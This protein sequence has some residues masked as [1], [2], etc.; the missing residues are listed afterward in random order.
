MVK[1]GYGLDSLQ[2][3]ELY[4]SPSTLAA[5]KKEYN[6]P[7]WKYS[8]K[9]TKEPINPDIREIARQAGISTGLNKA[10][11]C[12]ELEN[13]SKGNPSSVKAA[14]YD[15]NR[16]RISL[17]SVSTGDIVSGR[18]TLNGNRVLP[19]NLPSFDKTSSNDS[20]PN[21][22][23]TGVPDRAPLCTNSDT[24]A[25]P[26]EDFPEIDRV[27]YSDSMN[28]WCFTSDS[29]QELL[30]TGMNPWVVDEEG[31]TG[32]PLPD[33]V[34]VEIRQKLDTI[35]RNNLLEEPGSISKGVDEIFDSSVLK[36]EQLFENE[37][38]RRLLEFYNFVE[39]YGIDREVF[40]TLTSQD[41]QSF[42]DGVLSSQTRITVD[43]ES[44]ML[45]LRDF[46][47]AT[48]I[49]IKNF[50]SRDQIGNMLA[51]ILGSS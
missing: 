50:N 7:A 33:E 47:A 2:M 43:S 48:L 39:E 20:K 45:A 8:C 4:F 41:Y 46:A 14:T 16:T 44:P 11:V 42:A 37:S 35:R 23:P 28:T 22:T 38:D 40:L 19:S 49:E 30:N 3:R 12:S 9:L 24:L 5:V 15:V 36:T 18:K 31:R 34:L 32:A 10:Q 51:S 17:A 29:F 1:T 27:T 21:L 6:M 13:L 25:R 26:I